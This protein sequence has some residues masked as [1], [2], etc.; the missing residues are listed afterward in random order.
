[1]DMVVTATAIKKATEQLVLSKDP[2]V[3]VITANAKK[4]T[5]IAEDMERA[6]VKSTAMEV[7]RVNTATVI[8]ANVS[9]VSVQPAM[10]DAT[11]MFSSPR[12]YPINLVEF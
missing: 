2:T 11:K 7:H 1:M 8:T 9:M 12:C 4:D 5:F 6:M 10:V 3:T